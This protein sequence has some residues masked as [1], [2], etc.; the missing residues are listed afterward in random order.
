MGFRHPEPACRQRQV[1]FRV[2]LYKYW[3]KIC[4][5]MLKRVQH[6]AVSNRLL[7]QNAQRVFLFISIFI[8]LNMDE[9]MS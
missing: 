9:N 2:T 3:M 5:G 8:R 7:L 1:Y 6:D 4:D